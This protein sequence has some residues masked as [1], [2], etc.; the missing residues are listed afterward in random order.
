MLRD[1]RRLQIEIARQIKDGVYENVLGVTNTL[2]MIFFLM[3]NLSI[4]IGYKLK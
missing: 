1:V 2:K 3:E 4:S